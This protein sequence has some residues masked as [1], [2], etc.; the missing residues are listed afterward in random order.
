MRRFGCHVRERSRSRR[1]CVNCL[2]REPNLCEHV[3]G[4]NVVRVYSLLCRIHSAR[5]R[6]AARATQRVPMRHRRRVTLGLC[7][8]GSAAAAEHARIG[9]GSIDCAACCDTLTLPAARCTARCGCAQARVK[10]NFT[11]SADDAVRYAPKNNASK[12]LMDKT[13]CVRIRNG[14][15]LTR[16]AH[17]RIF[18]VGAFQKGCEEGIEVRTEAANRALVDLLQHHPDLPDATW[19]QDLGDLPRAAGRWDVVSNARRHDERCVCA[20]APVSS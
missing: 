5:A 10:R 1:R 13:L 9:A 3:T 19:L 4:V 14:E 15:L 11:V 16:P 6:G 2:R 8:L 20:D 18:C 7:F 12:L 17:G